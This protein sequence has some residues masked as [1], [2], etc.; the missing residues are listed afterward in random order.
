MLWRIAAILLWGI[1]A[2]LVTALAFRFGLRLIGVRPD[3]PFPGLIYS[4]TA[5]LVAPFYSFSPVSERFDYYATEWAAPLAAGSVL[6]AALAIHVAG[7]L[8]Y[9]LL[10]R[11]RGT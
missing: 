2:L 4:L 11:R 6:A 3:I 8:L 9:T 5:P 10:S 7:L 1:A